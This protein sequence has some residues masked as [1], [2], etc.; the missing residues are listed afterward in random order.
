M[1]CF[2]F[3]PL[4]FSIHFFLVISLFL[5][6]DILLRMPGV[7]SKNYRSIMNKVADIAELSTLSEDAL[8]GIM[9][10]SQHAKLLWDFLHK[11]H[12]EETASSSKGAKSETAR[13][14]T[15]RKR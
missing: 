10:S 5:F 1:K 11:E 13:K 12:S 9:G 8:T 3:F 14:W 6:Q 2:A 15:K 7:N 4:Y